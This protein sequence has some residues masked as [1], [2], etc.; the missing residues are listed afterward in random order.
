MKYMGSKARLAKHILPIILKDLKPEQTYAELFCGG[1][2]L[3]DK[4][5]HP[6]RLA[7]DVNKPLVDLWIAL[8]Q[9]WEPP[10]WVTKEDYYLIK[11]YRDTLYDNCLVGWASICLSYSGK[12]FSGF[13]GLHTSDTGVTR[14]YQ[15]ETYN[16][17]QKQILNL[18]DVKFTSLSYNEVLLPDNSIVYLDPPY[19]DTTGYR[20]KFD[21]ERFWD[22]SRE[23]VKNHSLFISEYSAPKDFICVW[24]GELKGSLNRK[25]IYSGSRSTVEKL[26][27]HESQ[28]DI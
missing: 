7:N 6:H 15:Q 24:S 27:V 10:K 12:P 17:V 13:A 25:G 26:F 18:K 20:V 19:K 16:Y 1:C 21:H 28:L 11:E 2:N 9:G 23:T 22:W 5:V 8:Q 14:N 4:V 3:I